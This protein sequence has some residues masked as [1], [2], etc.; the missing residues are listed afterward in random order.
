VLGDGKDE[1]SIEKICE[2][3]WPPKGSTVEPANQARI[4]LLAKDRLNAVAKPVNGAS[5]AFT[6]LFIGDDDGTAIQ[7]ER[8]TSL[9]GG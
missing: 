3:C 8:L 4:L 9:H 1:I 6:L 2:T 7:R 5:T